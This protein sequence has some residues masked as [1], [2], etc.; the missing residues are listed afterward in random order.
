M[1]AALEVSGLQKNFGGLSVLRDVSFAVEKDEIV[2]LVG[3]NGAGKSIL[4]DIITGFVRPTAGQ[5]HLDGKMVK[6][7]SGW[8]IARAGVGRTFQDLKLFDGLTV[9]QHLE[10]A[11]GRSS[12]AEKWSRHVLLHVG[13]DGK[14]DRPISALS[15]TERRRLAI[16]RAVV[17]KPSVLLLDEIMTG[18]NADERSELEAI[19]L[20]ISS[21]LERS[22][23]IVFVE[24]ILPV[25]Y[26]ICPRLLVL[27]VGEIIYDGGTQGARYNKRVVDA[28]LGSTEALGDEG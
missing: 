2:G 27:D 4:F 23:G 13:L 17:I 8:R 6:H 25:V 5:I 7:S 22:L 12:S 20:S 10:V 24:H 9:V 15:V 11:C 19:V 18:L 14:R 16:A 26:R 1:T 21:L 3:P 28:Y